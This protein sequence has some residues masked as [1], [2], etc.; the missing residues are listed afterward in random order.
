MRLT[1][2]DRLQFEA[3][4]IQEKITKAAVREVTWRRTGTSADVIPPRE[5]FPS[6]AEGRA[7][8]GGSPGE[9]SKI[10]KDSAAA[11]AP[12]AAARLARKTN[13]GSTG[14]FAPEAA[15][16]EAIRTKPN[17]RENEFM[18]NLMVLRNSLAAHAPACR[19]R[20]KRAGKWTW[21]DIRL[22]LRL[23]C[24]VQDALIKTM[25]ESRDDYYTAYAL[26]GHYELHIDGPVQTPR[27]LLIKDR[28]LAALAD[29]A[30]K[31]ECVLCMR[32]G[33][34]I[35]QCPLRAALLENAP[36]TE[37]QEG[38]WVQCEY[39]DAAGQLIQGKD[40]TI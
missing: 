2:I 3:A 28:H 29:A 9:G 21:R 31:S 5:P 14:A 33:S 30:M 35:G 22:M 20:A 23:V 24:K 1:E 16:R 17:K 18:M 11:R 25:P 26:H 19:E 39:R 13:E 6:A 36:P 34:E 4:R 7:G 27:Y 40:V 38:R 12:E 37:L 15:A 32:E 8:R 10:A